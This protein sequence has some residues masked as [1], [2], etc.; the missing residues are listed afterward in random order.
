MITK[1]TSLDFTSLKN[2]YTGELME[3]YMLVAP[4][5]EVRFS[6]PET[7]SPGD[8][9]DTPEACY[10][11]WN[12]VNGIEGP[13]QGS[14]ILCAYTGEPLSLVKSTFGGYRYLGGFDPR[15]LHTREEFLYYANMRNGESTMPKPAILERVKTDD[16]KK[17]VTERMKKHA[18]AAAPKLDEEKVHMVEESLQPFKDKMEGSS[19]VSMSM[20]SKKTNGK[21]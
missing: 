3:V 16:S 12:R 7:Y 20:S 17:H 19:T 6:A 11:K 14:L 18:E 8:V 13:K 15:M 21:R 9:F 1:V 2:P 4:S 10:R 5:G